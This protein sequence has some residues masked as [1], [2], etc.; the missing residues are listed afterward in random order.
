[1]PLANFDVFENRD[2]LRALS[3]AYLGYI[4]ELRQANQPEE[5]AKYQR[6]LGNVDPGALLELKGPRSPAPKPNTDTVRAQMTDDAF[7]DGNS[8]S[9]QEAK[10]LLVKAEQEFDA[11]RYESAG[12][13]FEQVEKTHKGAITAPVRERWAYCKLGSVVAVL[14]RQGGAGSVPHDLETE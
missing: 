3:D 1:T 7:D 12:K 14:N 11:K 5:A 13:L 9:A 10:T 4:V 2:Y 6:R 8:V